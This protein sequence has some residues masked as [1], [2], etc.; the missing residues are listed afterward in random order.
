VDQ[1]EQIMKPARVVG[2]RPV[3]QLDLHLPYQQV[4]RMWVGPADAG[5]HRRVLPTL[6]SS[7]CSNTLPSFP[8]W[9]AFPAS[10]YYDGSAPSTPCRQATCLSAPGHPGR[11]AATERKRG[12]FPRSLSSGQR[13]RHPALPL[14]HRHGYAVDLHRDLP[15]QAHGTL[16]EVPQPSTNDGRVRAANQPRS[17]GFELADLSRGLNTGSSRMPSRLAHQAR[18]IRQYQADPT[19]SRLLPPPPP[20]RGSGCRQLHPTATTARR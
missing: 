8:L 16:P 17:T 19:S 7:P 13:V 14:R 5:I 9:P 10:E 12:R 11:A 4:R 2:S 18:P 6:Q 1:V 15:G 20:S 3:M